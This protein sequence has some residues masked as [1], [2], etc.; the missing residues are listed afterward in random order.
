MIFESGPWK[1]Q[2]LRDAGILRRL[3]NACLDGQNDERS[4]ARLERLIFVS[5]YAMRKLREAG[6]LSTD[7]D[8]R[9]L[10]C[11]RFAFIGNSLPT[12]LN[13]HRIHEFYDLDNP[14]DVSIKPEEFCDR[15]IHS[16]IFV[17]V[18]SDQNC[19][20]GFHFTSDRLRSQCLWFVHLNDLAALMTRTGKEYP[21]HGTWIMTADSNVKTWAGDNKPPPGWLKAAKRQQEDS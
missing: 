19:I 11:V 13:A 16:F 7:W 10:S 2:L 6:K 1:D 4:L 20:E 3:G 15:I 17:P 9:K 12:I 5:A 18:I 8:S 21:S 14:K